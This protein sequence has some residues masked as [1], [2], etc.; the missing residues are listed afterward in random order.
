MI[1]GLIF[2][3]DGLILDTE[4]PTFT[5]W[6][7]IFL[8]AGCDIELSKWV[9]CVG[10]SFQTYDPVSDLETQAKRKFD[11]VRLMEE[12]QRRSHELLIVEKALP[13]VRE[14]IDEAQSMGLALGLASS[15]PRKWIDAHLSRL[16]LLDKFGCIRTMDDVKKVK[17]DP[18]L[19]LTTIECMGLS[20][21]E[22]IVFED[23][24]NGVI[25]AKKAGLA[26][27][28]IP[29]RLM[30]QFDYDGADFIATSMADLNL[31]DLVTFIENRQKA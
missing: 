15:S 1:K 22:G 21:N 4:T 24:L 25:A 17:P 30:T 23:S 14:I 19:F 13:G 26:C 8:A 27:V 28:A 12:Q 29:N 7:E 3:F 20:P 18:E 6:R 5:A 2:D 16:D 11:R 9:A 31:K 10:S